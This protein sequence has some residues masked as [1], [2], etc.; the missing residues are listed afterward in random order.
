MRRRP[1]E[2]GRSVRDAARKQAASS[3]ANLPAKSVKGWQ[4]EE[5]LGTL[6]AHGD[7]YH[8]VT[9]ERQSNKGVASGY[10]PLDSG[11]LV[12]L[13][14]L[15]ATLTGKDADTL[16]TYHAA[17]FVLKTLFD[18]YSILMA[19]TDDTPVALTVAEQRLV[20]RITGGAIAALTP[21]QIMALLSAGAA[22]AFSMNNQKITALAAAAANGDAVRYE[23]ILGLIAAAGDTL[24]GSGAG[25][26]AKLAKG[27]D[28]QIYKQ[29]S[30]VPSWAWDAGALEYVIDGAGAAITAGIKGT[31]EAPWPCFVTG[32]TILGDASGSIV[33]TVKKATYANYP[34]TMTT[35]SGTQ[36]PTLSAAQKGQDL[37]LTT[38]TQALAL[39]DIVEFTV[40]ALATTV[41]RVMVSLQVDKYRTA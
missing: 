25:V 22:A 12:P 2:I 19:T 13:A 26:L 24:Y 4:L 27:T 16:D 28:G 29:A 9:Y 7:S 15:P 10:C 38:W 20:G 6:S 30:G 31:L 33:I 1:T 40:D 23:Q 35:I 14:Y 18:A 5:G 21:A 11:I 17:S 32:W 37:T 41:T 39:R 36:K 3:P 34:G 8:T